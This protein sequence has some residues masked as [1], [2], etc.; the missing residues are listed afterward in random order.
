MTERYGQRHKTDEKTAT[1]SVLKKVKGNRA[2]L[3]I[4]RG[5]KL[6]NE[7]TFMN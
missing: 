4:K 1:E 3:D 7:K 5:F 6:R 2:A